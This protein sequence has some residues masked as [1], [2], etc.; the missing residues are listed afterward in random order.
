MILKILTNGLYKRKVCG[1][2]IHH[3]LLDDQK[4]AR[5]EQCKNYINTIRRNGTFLE[6]IAT[7]NE[8]CRF[9]YVLKQN[10]KMLR[11]LFQILQNQK[12]VP[13]R[14]NVTGKYY[15][16]LRRVSGSDTFSSKA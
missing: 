12:F 1:R 9:K 10:V 7:G 14:Q 4:I 11:K 16:R 3:V 15:V 8:T 2:F 6:S 5:V 13:Q